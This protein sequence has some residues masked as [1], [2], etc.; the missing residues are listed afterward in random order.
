MNLL[1]TVTA[2]TAELVTLAEARRHLRIWDASD[3]LEDPYIQSLIDSA[4]NLMDGPD[5]IIGRA[6]LEQTVEITLDR[7]PEWCSGSYPPRIKLPLPPLIEVVSVKYND[8]N[9]DETTLS[10]VRAFG[11]G[12]K[13]GGYIMPARNE[14]WPTTDCEP[15]SVR[16]QITAGYNDDVPLPATFKHAALLLIS[17]WFEHRESAID[18]GAKFGLL[19]LPFGFDRLINP[20]RVR[21]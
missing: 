13:W 20:L 17:H 2:P 12:A 1:S 16:I 5:G 6:L 15:G 10:G 4:T 19:E 18:S 21:A 9:G 8:A 3:T 14:D 7:F 11:I